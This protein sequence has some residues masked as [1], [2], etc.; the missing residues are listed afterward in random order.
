VT[1]DQQVS[2][3]TPDGC[4]TLKLQWF[5]WFGEFLADIKTPKSPFGTGQMSD[6]PT[7]FDPPPDGICIKNGAALIN[8]KCQLSN[9]FGVFRIL[10]FSSSR[11]RVAKRHDHG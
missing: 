4:T 1:T 11:I 7:D 3:S 9:K 5:Q 10:A 6:K 8:G 2:G